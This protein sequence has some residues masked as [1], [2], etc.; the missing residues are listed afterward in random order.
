MHAKHAIRKRDRPV[1]EWW[2][3]EV[4]HAVQ[5]SGDPI[6]RIEHGAGDLCLHGIHVV[7]ERRR[8]DDASQKNDTGDQQN[9]HVGLSEEV[10]NTAPTRAAILPLGVER[11]SVSRPHQ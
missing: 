9:Q 8:A 1:L 3:F 7:H 5:M 4:T 11:R 6:P 2:F 10:P